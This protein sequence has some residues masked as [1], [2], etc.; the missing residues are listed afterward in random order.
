MSRIAEQ[1]LPEFV[2]EMATTRR[3]LA[4]VPADRADWKPHA[5]SFS[6]AHLALHLA[7]V[8]S[9]TVPMLTLPELDMNPPGGTPPER[10]T[11][12]T[13]EALL[14][15]FD[16]HVA[17]ATAAL[18]AAD[19]A[20]FGDSWTLK[21]SGHVVFSMPKATALRS[22]VLN[23]NVHHRAQLGVYLRLLDVPVPSMYGPS[24]DE[25]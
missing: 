24:A 18:E 13:V 11:F 14:A 3:V 5:K 17:A 22:F 16:A 25:Q 9:W 10:P 7:E 4:R 21:S 2:H 19:D 23:H 12:T 8:P 20:V 1:L 6:L 15:R